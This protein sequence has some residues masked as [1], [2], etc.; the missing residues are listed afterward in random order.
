MGL[1][2]GLSMGNGDAVALEGEA[3]AGIGVG[4]DR[5]DVG[6]DTPG[7]LVDRYGAGDAVVADVMRNNTTLSSAISSPYDGALSFFWT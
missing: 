7:A 2:L 3:V 4:E 6:D 1:G 5:G